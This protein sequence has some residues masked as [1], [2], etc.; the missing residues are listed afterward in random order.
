MHR[1]TQ[2]F[3]LLMVTAAIA[4]ALGLLTVSHGPGE[5]RIAAVGLCLA[6]GTIGPLLAHLRFLQRSPTRSTLLDRLAYASM[7]GVFML[8][9]YG[10]ATDE[11]GQGMGALIFAPLAAMLL[12]CW[13]GRIEAGRRGKVDGRAAIWPA[14]IGLVTAHI[15]DAGEYGWT[16]A[17]ICAAISLLTQAA[18]S[19][20]P[21]GKV[22][23]GVPPAG[24]RLQ[25]GPTLPVAAAPLPAEVGSQTPTGVTAEA[26][27]PHG[28]PA[29]PEV[30][31]ANQPSFVGR[32]ANAGMSFLGKILLLAGLALALGQGAAREYARQAVQGGILQVNADTQ[33]VIDKGLPR[34]VVS[35][36][37]LVG[38]LLLVT[39]RRRQGAMHFLRGCVGCAFVVFG[40][41]AAMLWASTSLELLFTTGDLNKLDQAHLW[42]PALLAGLPLA[43]GLVLLLWPHEQAQQTIVV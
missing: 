15:L 14:I 33:S 42:G 10:M 29:P 37:L 2:L 5:S 31:Q 36:P 3:L 17:G 25:T 40:A 11:V 24:D 23:P 1:R 4:T 20:W 28:P 6:G 26:P 22:A 16:A 32:T 8:P 35:L 39:A 27:L 7:A 12:C 19:M 30:V 38:S 43:V 9:A 41:L 21:A 18:A 34:G 13:N